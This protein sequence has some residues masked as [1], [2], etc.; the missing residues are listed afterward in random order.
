MKNKQL[1]FVTYHNDGFDEGFTY[2]LDLAKTLKAGISILMLY[3][4]KAME[5]LE[6]A[7]TIA[8][9]AEEG[10]F[11]TARELISNDLKGEYDNRIN[12]LKKKCKAAG[13]K[14]DVST[15][16]SGLFPAIR[17]LLRQND[18]IEMILLSSGVTVESSVTPKELNRFVKTASRPVVTISKNASAA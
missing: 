15:A 6:D 7:M 1:L 8:S 5:K 17:N 11:K 13:V 10:D 9:F 4:R 16:A 12:T 14:M 18:S 3:K 2:A